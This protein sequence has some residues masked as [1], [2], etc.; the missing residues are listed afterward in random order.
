MAPYLND[1][2]LEATVEPILTKLQTEK[3][4]ADEKLVYIQ[5]LG[6]LRWCPC[7]SL[8]H[9]IVDDGAVI[10]TL[11][12]PL[13]GTSPLTYAKCVACALVWAY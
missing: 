12:F 3:L 9:V 7:D 1:A 11:A 8:D 5:A 10:E 13:G 4:E 2:L 6:T